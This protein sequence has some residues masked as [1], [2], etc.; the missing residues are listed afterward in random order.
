M[1]Y[2]YVTAIV[3]KLTTKI[4]FTKT[5]ISMSNK[6]LT[7][8]SIVTSFTAFS[9]LN[10]SSAEA[11]PPNQ[12]NGSGFAN[13]GASTFGLNRTF[14]SGSV[15]TA[16]SPSSAMTK[17]NSTL[18]PITISNPTTLQTGANSTSNAGSRL[19]G[20]GSST[21]TLTGSPTQITAENVSTAKL[22]DAKTGSVSAGSMSSL[23][24]RTGL[25]SA[26]GGYEYSGGR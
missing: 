9:L 8:C 24:S 18:I 6:I 4:L 11:L 12:V 26:N 16:T 3:N 1:K 21:S 14:S 19:Q 10:I 25:G 5:I 23:D 7:F 2:Y 17:A 13:V 22:T 15:G 20:N